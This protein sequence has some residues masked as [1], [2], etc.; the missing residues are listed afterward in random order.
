MIIAGLTLGQIAI[1]SAVAGAGFGVGNEIGSALGK[2]A[3]AAGTSLA[4]SAVGCAEDAYQT[5]T[6]AWN[7]ARSSTVA[8]AATA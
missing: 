5:I 4:A 3:L 7:N 8:Q 1:G 6:T 2:A